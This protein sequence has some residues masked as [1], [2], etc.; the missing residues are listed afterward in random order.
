MNESYFQNTLQFKTYS[1][2]VQYTRAVKTYSWQ[3]CNLSKDDI[4]FIFFPLINCMTVQ[5]GR[6]VTAKTIVKTPFYQ[7]S[8]SDDI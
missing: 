8:V 5:T 7:V 4:S 6:S 3:K 1:V 2:N